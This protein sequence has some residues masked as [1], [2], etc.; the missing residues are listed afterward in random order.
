MNTLRTIDDLRKA[1]RELTARSGASIV[2]RV[3]STGCR[4][5]GALDVCDALESE[6]AKR[7]LQDRVRVVRAGCH[8]LCAGAVAVVIDPAGIFYQAVTPKDVPEIVEKT[9]LAGEV[10][11]R[12]C[13]SC[14]GQTVEHQRDIPFYKH[15]NKLVLRNCGMVDPQSIEDA[16]THAPTL[17]LPM[18]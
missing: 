8:G 14:D 15:Q 2:V 11:P 9:L 18:R 3:C 5:L 12:L 6:I 4:A 1:H 13:W 16:I 10:V 17:P 7:D